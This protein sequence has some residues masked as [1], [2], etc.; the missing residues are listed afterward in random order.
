M[1][2]I[3]RKVAIG[4]TALVGAAYLDAKLDLRHDLNII[5]AGIVQSIT[6]ETSFDK[7]Y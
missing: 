2:H 5:T 7:L 6:F 1:D 3:A 4:A